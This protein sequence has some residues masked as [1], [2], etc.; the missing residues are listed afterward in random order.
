MLYSALASAFQ[1]LLNLNHHQGKLQADDDDLVKLKVFCKG[2]VDHFSPIYIYILYIY[3]L[4]I[5]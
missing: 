5:Y 3:I 2:R 4:Y 1:F